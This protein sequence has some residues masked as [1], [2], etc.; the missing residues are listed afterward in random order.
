MFCC[1]NFAQTYLPVED[2]DK[3]KK[4]SRMFACLRMG[5]KKGGGD[6]GSADQQVWFQL[7][8]QSEL[9][10]DKAG[11]EQCAHSYY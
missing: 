7:K 1:K 10:W 4:K 8:F 3:P 2:D 11:L 6:A 5:K 9:S